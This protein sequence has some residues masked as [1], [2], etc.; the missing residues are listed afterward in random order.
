MFNSGPKNRSMYTFNK[1]G[2]YAVMGDARLPSAATSILF[3]LILRQLE[4][5][6]RTC[7]NGRWPVITAVLML[8][9]FS[10]GLVSKS[11]WWWLEVP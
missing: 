2:C 8:W 10:L 5:N 3:W 1:L 11:L 6:S 9:P 4:A 7:S